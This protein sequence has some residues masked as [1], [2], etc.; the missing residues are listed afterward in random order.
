MAYGRNTIPVVTGV[1]TAKIL[2]V[3]LIIM[4]VALLYLVWYF[5]LNDKITLVYLSCAV[6]IPLIAGCI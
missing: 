3:S 6:T 4:T 5:L 2:S 1:M